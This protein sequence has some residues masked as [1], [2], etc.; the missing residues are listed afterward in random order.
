MSR[1]TEYPYVGKELLVSETEVW[2]LVL[3]YRATG[4][5]YSRTHM[6]IVQGA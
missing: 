2:T 1:L 6:S 3:R 5:T 4:S